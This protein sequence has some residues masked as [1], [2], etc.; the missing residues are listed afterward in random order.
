[1]AK[2]KVSINDMVKQLKKVELFL[3]AVQELK[4]KLDDNES[5]NEEDKDNE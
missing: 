3:E 5:N 1:M 4:E 2:R